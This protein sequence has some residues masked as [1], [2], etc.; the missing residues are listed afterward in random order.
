MSRRIRGELK[1][2]AAS[3]KASN[4]TVKEH[5]LSLLY[6]LTVSSHAHSSLTF[7][8]KPSYHLSRI[9]H[10]VHQDGRRSNLNTMQSAPSKPLIYFP[11]RV[12]HP[13]NFCSKH[14]VVTIPISFPQSCLSSSRPTKLPTSST[15]RPTL[16]A[17]VPCTSVLSTVPMRFWICCWI[18]K[19][20]RSTE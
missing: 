17:V 6:N 15:L 20:W 5:R 14:A 2:R 7:C 13:A 4:Q 8:H 12:P 18:K 9:T 16:W 3:P 1:V 10:T 11:P 19:A